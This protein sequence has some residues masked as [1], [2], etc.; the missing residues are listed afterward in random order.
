MA[1]LLKNTW[2]AGRLNIDSSFLLLYIALN[3][4]AEKKGTLNLA[5]CSP[6][7]SECKTFW[8]ILLLCCS[9]VLD[10][11]NAESAL[12]PLLKWSSENNIQIVRP[13]LGE[14]LSKL[15]SLLY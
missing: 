6:Q 11:S 14:G 12:Q 13:I 10:I 15:H 8:S 5:S 3:F 1:P 9:Y 2:L 4:S 7:K